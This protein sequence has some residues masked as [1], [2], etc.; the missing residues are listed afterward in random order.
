MSA[1]QRRMP[2]TKST[3]VGTECERREASAAAKC[4]ERE[5]PNRHMPRHTHGAASASTAAEHG[6]RHSVGGC[7]CQPPTPTAAS[8]AASP[9][10]A[11]KRPLPRAA[12]GLA[13]ASA[14][15]KRPL[16]KAA[17]GAVWRLRA[18]HRGCR[19]ATV[20]ERRCVGKR[21]CR[22]TAAERC[23]RCGVAPSAASGTASRCRRCL[24]AASAASQTGRQQRPG[25]SAAVAV[26]WEGRR[27]EGRRQRHAGGEARRWRRGRRR[28]RPRR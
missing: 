4:G 18:R 28:W 2:W 3:Q 15:A 7:G 5:L 16:P 9:S 24:G 17:R 11:A 14:A 26:S 10:A 27:K 19:A 1:K 12:S 23:E 25:G 21:G 8:G 20:A 6:E 22:A 13:S